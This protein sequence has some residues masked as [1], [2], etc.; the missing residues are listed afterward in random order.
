MHLSSENMVTTIDYS[1]RT[2]A[3]LFANTITLFT[4]TA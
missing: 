3:Y 2:L 4:Y 1:F